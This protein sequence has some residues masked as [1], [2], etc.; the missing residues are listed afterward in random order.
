MQFQF[1]H[2]TVI[3]HRR[4]YLHRNNSIKK[5]VLQTVHIILCNW[6]PFYRPYS[7]ASQTF[8]CFADRRSITD[9]KFMQNIDFIILLHSTVHKKN[10]AALTLK[11]EQPIIYSNCSP[12]SE[13]H[14]T[15]TLLFSAHL[16]L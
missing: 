10:L 1:I 7:F 9:C 3:S 14:A 2:L 8:I 13:F 4:F 15:L 5:T 6:L 11:K 12:T 16:Y